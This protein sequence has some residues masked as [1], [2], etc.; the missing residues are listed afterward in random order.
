MLMEANRQQRD[1]GHA[2]EGSVADFSLCGWL[3]VTGSLMVDGTS[4]K[5]GA[6]VIQFCGHPRMAV[7]VITRLDNAFRILKHANSKLQD[8]FAHL[9]HVTSALAVSLGEIAE[10]TQF[11]ETDSMNALSHLECS[12]TEESES[13][14]KPTKSFIP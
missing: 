11:R 5:P 9:Q 14:I 8:T 12:E 7:D 4:K 1:A 6:E 13:R 10:S 2:D 3:A